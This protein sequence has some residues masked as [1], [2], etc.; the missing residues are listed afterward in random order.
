V[1]PQMGLDFANH[2]RGKAGVPDHDHGSKVM[3]PGLE[4]PAFAWS[5]FVHGRDSTG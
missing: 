2:F 1:A 4:F 3:R 5:K